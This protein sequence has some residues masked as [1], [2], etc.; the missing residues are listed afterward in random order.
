MLLDLRLPKVGG[1]EVLRKV[2]ADERTKTTPIVILTSSKEEQDVIEGY[3]LG[4]NSYI[5]KP[6]D[7]DAFADTV[8]KLGMYWLIVNKAPS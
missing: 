8:A 7:F 4:V 2:K 3:K 5:A 6:V 1:L